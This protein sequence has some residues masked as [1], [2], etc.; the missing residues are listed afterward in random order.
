MDKD[1]L[2][3]FGSRLQIFAYLPAF[4]GPSIYGAKP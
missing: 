3:L 2:Y 4:S 1:D